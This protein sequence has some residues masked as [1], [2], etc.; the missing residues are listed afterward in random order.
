MK[1]WGSGGIAPH[2]LN[3]GMRWRWVSGQLLTLATIPQGKSPQYALD[4]RL[5]G[6]HSQSGHS[7]D[8]KN[9]ISARNWTLVTILTKLLLLFHLREARGIS[10]SMSWIRMF[11]NL[12][13][14]CLYES[15]EKDLFP[16]LDLYHLA[17][18]I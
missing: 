14:Y 9:S 1:Y 15:T 6:P 12:C 16:Y 2:I 7:E 11:E 8:K 5:G 13:C 3:H 18:S 4:R 10:V 17:Q